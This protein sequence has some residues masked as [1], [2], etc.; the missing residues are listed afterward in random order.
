MLEVKEFVL[1]AAETD[2]PVLVTGET[3]TG[4]D[5][6]TGAI[7]ACS[8]RGKHPP[9][10]VAPGLQE[11][12]W[13]TLFGHRRGAF[14]GAHEDSDGLFLAADKSSLIF[15]DVSDIPLKIQPMLLRAVEHGLFRPLGSLHEKSSR[16]R[17]LSSTNALMDAHLTS[18]QFRADLFQR[19]SV[20]TL[21]M[22]PLREHVSDLDIYVPAFLSRASGPHQPPKQLTGEAMEA[23]KAYPWPRN[24]RELEHVMLRAHLE[25]RSQYIDGRLIERILRGPHTSRPQVFPVSGIQ[26]HGRRV[27]VPLAVL[28]QVIAEAGGN[29][30]EAARR[31]GIAPGT[32]YAVLRKLGLSH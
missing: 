16:A 20:L 15:E 23:L 9:L 25:S 17:I 4:K 5:M 2:W 10:I 8:P 22:P 13:S 21:H 6:V 28:E 31:L 26:R 3:G 27:D 12:A 32:F 14:T 18:G 1:K 24:I 30:R 11:T 19:L 7:H 29:K